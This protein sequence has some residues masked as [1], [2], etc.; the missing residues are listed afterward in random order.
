M[1]WFLFF[2]IFL[3]SLDKY[4]GTVLKEAKIF[5]FRVHSVRPFFLAFFRGVV[6]S[7]FSR[8]VA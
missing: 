6:K 5:S 1:L 7:P 2:V 8:I 4:M 3:V